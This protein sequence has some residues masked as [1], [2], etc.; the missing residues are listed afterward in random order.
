MFVR[1]IAGRLPYTR[2]FA[3]YCP[4]QLAL[5]EAIH[6]RDAYALTSSFCGESCRP[7]FPRLRDEECCVDVN[8]LLRYAIERNSPLLKVLLV[9]NVETCD[10]SSL[11]QTC[12]ERDNLTA[13]S[14]LLEHFDESFLSESFQAELGTSGNLS[15][16]KKLIFF[17]QYALRGLLTAGHFEKASIYARHHSVS[18]SGITVKVWEET[19]VGGRK[20]RLDALTL[21]T[22]PRREKQRLLLSTSRTK[23]LEGVKYLLYGLPEA[24]FYASEPRKE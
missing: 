3:A 5:Q 7:L 9:H 11:F 12:V 8:A 14:L 16:L 19:P 2:C 4:T 23:Y 24:K 15:F 1:F 22:L 21:L 6:R 13:F 10:F 18:R 17:S 20:I